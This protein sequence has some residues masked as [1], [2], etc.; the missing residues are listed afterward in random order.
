MSVGFHDGQKRAPESLELVFQA[1]VRQLK[2]SWEPNSCPLQE[3]CMLL[4]GV[5][6]LQPLNLEF[7]I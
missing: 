7:Y 4:V 1:V 5:S 2:Y 6:S 3:Q